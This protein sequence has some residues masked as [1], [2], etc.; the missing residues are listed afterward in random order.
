MKRLIIVPHG[1]RYTNGGFGLA[2]VDEKLRALSPCCGEIIQ[3]SDCTCVGCGFSF[4]DWSDFTKANAGFWTP[5]WKLSS[6]VNPYLVSLV[7]DWYQRLT[8]EPTI[9]IEVDSPD[10]PF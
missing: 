8:Q 3:Y 7:E 6:D 9:T 1:D 2:V 10:L 5:F 4:R